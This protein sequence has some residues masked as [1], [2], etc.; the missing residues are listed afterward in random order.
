MIH[1]DVAH[2]ISD[3]RLWTIQSEKTER[4]EIECDRVEWDDILHI[5]EIIHSNCGGNREIL[6]AI[7]Q[8]LRS[9]EPNDMGSVYVI[10]QSATTFSMLYKLSWLS[11]G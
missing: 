8:L 3:I 6:S 5:T 10:Y 4:N 1:C 7:Y 2:V 9:N 11:W